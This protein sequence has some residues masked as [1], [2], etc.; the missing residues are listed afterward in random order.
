MKKSVSVVVMTY[1]EANSLK[2][3]IIEV[4]DMLTQLNCQYEIIIVDDG[5]TDGSSEIAEKLATKYQEVRVVH[6]GINLGIGGVYRTGFTEVKNDIVTFM[7]ADGQSLA[8]VHFNQFLP[9][10]D[11][12][13][14]A[15]GCLPRRDASVLSK[16]FAWGEKQFFRVLF[17]GVP[18][19]E[20]PFMFKR[21]LLDEIHL[22]SMNDTNRGWMVVWELIIRAKYQG[23]KLITVSTK[24]GKRTHGKS[25]A[26]TWTNAITMIFVAIIFRM[27][28]KR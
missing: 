4:L 22:I 25:K 13:D 26:N 14:M 9:L 1:N 8:E 16:F 2:N 27:K 6:H 15:L 3:V 7:A 18:K 21:R 11:E 20:G 19:P 28:F 17:P 23:Y 12:Y 5:S 10:L 24:S